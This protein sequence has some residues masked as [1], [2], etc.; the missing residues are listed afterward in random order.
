MLSG[1]RCPTFQQRVDFDLAGP[2]VWRG[3]YN[4]GKTNS[5]NNRFLDLECGINRVAVRSTRVPGVITISARCG[6]LRPASVSLTAESVMVKDGFLAQLPPLPAPPA[7]DAIHQLYLPGDE[8]RREQ[9]GRRGASSR[10]SPIRARR[11]VLVQQDA[12]DGARI[13]TDRDSCLPACLTC[14]EGAIGC[15]PPTPTSSTARWT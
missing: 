11:P 14:F 1:D 8:R 7:L 12:R 15:R 6:E 5:I 4:S 10:T 3:G 13:Y 2:G 9:K